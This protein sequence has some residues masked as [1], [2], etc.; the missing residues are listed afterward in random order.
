MV[1]TVYYEWGLEERFK[2]ASD[3]HEEDEIVDTHHRDTYRALMGDLAR[4][5]VD[6]EGDTYQAV[7][8]IRNSD[9]QG[10]SWAYMED[11]KLP[12]HFLDA[13]DVEVCPVP[14]RFVIDVAVYSASL[15]KED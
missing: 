8:L 13:C 9:R 12:S 15:K 1:T 3:D 6:P 11:G 5:G 4:F 7:V 14:Q 2:A 10:R